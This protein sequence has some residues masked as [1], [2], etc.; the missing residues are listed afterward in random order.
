MLTSENIDGH[1]GICSAVEF[2][3]SDQILSAGDDHKLL[4]KDIQENKVLSSFDLGQD[5][6]PVDLAIL[7]GNKKLFTI[8]IGSSDG[9]VSLFTLSAGQIRLEKKWAAH[10][11]ACIQCRASPNGTEILTCGEDGTVKIWSKSG[12]LRTTLASLGQAIYAVAWSPDGTNVVM[13]QAT[14]IQTKSI[15]PSARSEIWNAHSALITAISW[16]ANDIIASGGEDGKYKLWDRFGRQ[17]YSSPNMTNQPITAIA[18]SPN[19]STLLVGTFGMVLLCDQ[20]GSVISSIHEPAL[21]GSIFRLSWS[22]DGRVAIGGSGSGKLIR[23]D[24]GGMEVEDLTHNLSQVSPKKIEVTEVENSSLDV[25]ETTERILS[26]TVGFRHII[27]ITTKEIQVFTKGRMNTPQMIQHRDINI[28]LVKQAPNSFLVLDGLGVT[29]YSYEGRVMS[30][31]KYQFSLNSLQHN[32]IA[33]NSNFCLLADPREPKYILGFEA[34]TGKPLA[35]SGKSDS[36]PIIQHKDQ[37]KQLTLQADSKIIAFLDAQKEVYITELSSTR[38]AFIRLLSNVESISF[39]STLPVLGFLRDSVA[40]I[41]L[42]PSVIMRD[43]SL[44]NDSVVQMNMEHLGRNPNFIG[45][46]ETM[47]SFKNS[48]GSTVRTTIPVYAQLLLERIKQKKLQE[49]VSICRL[50]NQKYLWAVLGGYCLESGE[51][52]VMQECFSALGHVDKL[53]QINKIQNM[54]NKTSQITEIKLLGNDK[55]ASRG[56]LKQASIFETIKILIAQN[57]W[58]QALNIAV[59]NESHVDT[60]LYMRQLFLKKREKNETDSKFIEMAQ[61]IDVEW[62]DVKTKVA[63]EISTQ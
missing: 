34:T 2:V 62:A 26:M 11:G 20:S 6:Y 32:Q 49:A 14:K 4:L 51:L 1:R 12:L 9:K 23:I 59:K 10:Q 55:D 28:K 8:C 29:I 54:D 37:I 36:N 63:Q 47:M 30:Q 52:N 24:V 27:C 50:T 15:Q 41:V 45:F 44:L 35:A 39:S 7:G 38:I 61:N 13:S 21:T 3:A 56:L 42:N 60:V 53:E 17:L 40:Q 22:T 33:L 31:S 57:E 43:P 18:F 58:T 46:Y 48:E 25:I 16:G 5:T 19:N